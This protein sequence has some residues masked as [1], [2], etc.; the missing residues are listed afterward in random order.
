MILSAGHHIRMPRFYRGRDIQWWMDRS[1]L[2]ATSIDRV[3]GQRVTTISANLQGGA[4]LGEVMQRLQHDLRDLALPRDFSLIFSG[5]YR[6]Q[7]AARR[8]FRRAG[9]PDSQLFF[10]S[11]DYAAPDPARRQAG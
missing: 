7:Q 1:G 9:L 11:F 5:E 6:E 2:L 8:D 3:D 10:D 4:A